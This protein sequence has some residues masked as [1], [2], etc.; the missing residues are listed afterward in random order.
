MKCYT[1]H[2]FVLV[3]SQSNTV[4]GLGVDK[5]LFSMGNKRGS[6]HDTGREAYRNVEMNVWLNE[7]MNDILIKRMNEYI[8]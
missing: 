6:I 8:N 3:C 4:V 5:L 1:F 7:S 2:T